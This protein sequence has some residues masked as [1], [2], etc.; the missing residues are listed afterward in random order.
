MTNSYQ[1]N[2]KGKTYE[3]TGE[4]KDLQIRNFNHCIETRDWIT[5]KNRVNNQL[6]WTPKDLVEIK[7]TVT[8]KELCE[9]PVQTPFIPL[10][11]SPVP[12]EIKKENNNNKFW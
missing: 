4:D 9:Q 6:K 1:F 12:K 5:I 8:L 3:C 7:D 2:F 10:I 11:I